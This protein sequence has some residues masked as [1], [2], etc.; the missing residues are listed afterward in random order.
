[1]ES[2]WNVWVW[3]VGVVSRRW[4]WLAKLKVWKTI[5]ESGW[6]VWLWLVGVVSGCGWQ[7]VGVANKVKS[8][9]DNCGE[10]VECIASEI[11]H[12]IIIIIKFLCKYFSLHF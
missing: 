5:V 11:F 9:D 1:M 3:L 6:N 7:E 4:V 2:G 12:M 8:M 10:W